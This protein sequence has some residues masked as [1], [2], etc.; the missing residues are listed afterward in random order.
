MASKLEII[1]EAFVAFV[2]FAGLIS[3]EQD[4]RRKF[5]ESW[6]EQNCYE[7]VESRWSLFGGPFWWTAFGKQTKYFVRIRDNTGH[8]RSGWVLCGGWFLGILSD[9]V[10]VIWN[11][12]EAA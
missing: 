2:V 4:R 6:A 10:K 5:L 1:G 12:D 11:S 3:W 7:I 9:R 8:T